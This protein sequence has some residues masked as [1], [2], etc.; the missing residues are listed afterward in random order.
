MAFKALQSPIKKTWVFRIHTEHKTEADLRTA[1]QAV[2]GLFGVDKDLFLKALVQKINQFLDE[3][4]ALRCVLYVL[5]DKSFQIIILR[6]EINAV[7]SVLLKR[8][9]WKRW[10]R[11]NRILY[12]LARLRAGLQHAESFMEY[13]DGF[14]FNLE[15]TLARYI[16]T[17]QRKMKRYI[18]KHR[19]W[20]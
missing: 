19:L 12:K 13:E 2:I 10:R 6:P 9:M 4:V 14:L 11:F 15:Y 8:W 3:E 1:L 20:Y 17:Q 16:K 7:I 5:Q 18:L